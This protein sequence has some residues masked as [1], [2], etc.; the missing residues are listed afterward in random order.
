[1]STVFFYF[2]W[3]ICL[4]L[5]IKLIITPKLV[6]EYPYFMASM[7]LIFIAPQ[8]II[9]YNHPRLVPV[10]GLASVLLM[11]CLCLGMAALGYI[12]APNIKIGNQLKVALDAHKLKIIGLVF[13]AVGYFVWYKMINNIDQVETVNGSQWTGIFTIYVQLFQ[14]INVAFPLFLYLAFRKPNLVNICLTIIAGFPLLHFLVFLGRREMTA[15]FFLAIAFSLYYR[16]GFVA[17]RAVIIAV[18]VFATLFIP[19]TGDY[20]N[21]AEKVGPAKALRDLDLTTG[22]ANY[23]KNGKSLELRVASHLIDTYAFY[24]DYGYGRGYWNY[25]IF[26]YVPAQIIGKDL[27]ESL[28]IEGQKREHRFRNGFR[29]QLGLTTTG[30]GDAFSQFGYLGSLFFFFLGGLFRSLWQFSLKSDNPLVQILYIVSVVQALL[31]ITH[32]TVTFLPGIFFSFICLLIA[33]KYAKQ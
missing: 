16:Y 26:R 11:C 17:P 20:R 29:P 33:A 21:M 13:T 4:V 3:I 24:G 9:I 23:F 10:D 30:M 22:F 12:W 14:C 18:I 2:F 27:K 28:F 1:M 15:F 6:L 7:F 8:T 5:I 32:S 31:C 19:A 25:M